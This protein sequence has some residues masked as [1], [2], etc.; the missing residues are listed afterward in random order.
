MVAPFAQL[1][2][3]GA[4]CNFTGARH[5][6]PRPIAAALVAVDRSIFEPHRDSRPASLSI[7]YKFVAAHC[8]ERGFDQARQAT[9][10][11]LVAGCESLARA[12]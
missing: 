4:R 1:P 5:V 3:P 2:I 10:D 7:A 8:A 12:R 6:V 9:P 11:D